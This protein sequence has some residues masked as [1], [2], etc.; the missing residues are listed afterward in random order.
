MGTKRS[1][2]GN[3]VKEKPGILNNAQKK[4]QLEMLRNARGFALDA[5]GRYE[6]ALKAFESAR[7]SSVDGKISCCGK[8][9]VF[10]HLGDWERTYKAFDRI[11]VFDPENT[12]ASIMKAFALIRLQKFEK[13]ASI[14]EELTKKDANSDLPACLLGLACSKLEDFEKALW[15]YK[16]AIEIKPKNFHAR[17]GLAELY[18]RLGNSRGALKELEASLAEAPENSF[19]RNL[20]GR[21]EL[22]E[23][24]C[25]DALESFRR[26]LDLDSKDRRL[27]LWDAYARYIYAEASF[28]EESTRFRYMIL[29]AAGKLEKAFLSLDAG[30]HEL[31][32][33]A[34]YFMGL[35]Y[36]RARHFRKAAERLEECLKLKTP[37]EV[38]K[39]ASLLLK[40]I[41]AGPLRPSWWKWWLDAEANDLVKKAGFGFIFL[42]ILS[43]LLSHPAALSIPIISWPA[44]F[45]NRIFSAAGAEHI[46]WAVY[47]REYL[48]F[49]L[50]LLAVLLTPAVRFGRGGKEELE[51]EVLTPPAPDFDIPA[52]ILDE[53]TER[54]EKNL[55]FPEPMEERIQKLVKF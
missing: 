6:D 34:L 43:L 38:K 31:K 19:S 10:A 51:L 7:R 29:A 11:L 35:F 4:L 36:C 18:F 27:L 20:K 39:P 54:L 44:S 23:Q 33:Y 40:S 53:I 32:A 2:N 21:I 50:F 9:L 37:D 46:S 49:I 14:L 8:G 24:A 16:R 55:F 17:N 42:L 12:Q 3:E 47:G 1:E 28:E 41:R 15:A 13:A 22:E 25:E 5:F 26:A 52:S 30:D 48:I 45:I